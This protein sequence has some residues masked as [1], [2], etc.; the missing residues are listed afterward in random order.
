[1]DYNPGTLS[2]TTW[3]RR[4]VNSGS[5]A[6]SILNE[7]KITVE[8][9]TAPTITAPG[10]VTVS[11]NASCEATGVALGT[12]VTA[13][14]CSVASVSNNAPETF[15]LGE[16]TVTWTVID[17]AGL[18]A[19]AEQTV[20]VEDNIAPTVVTQNITVQ[21]D[22]NGSATITA[23]QI[24]NGST[25][26]CSIAT[27]ALDITS[28]DCDNVGPN[29]VTLTVTDVNG[30][31][32]SETATVTVEDNVAPII[33]TSAKDLTVESDGM[34]NAVEFQNWLDNNGGAEALDNCNEITWTYEFAPISDDCGATGSTKV[35]FKAI[36]ASGNTSTTT[37]TFTIEDTTAP[38]LSEI[39]PIVPT[40]V[41]TNFTLTVPYVDVNGV[42]IATWYFNSDGVAMGTPDEVKIPNDQNITGNSISATFNF[43]ESQAGVYSVLLVVKDACGN[44]AEIGYDYVVVYDPSGGFITGGGWIYS[45]PG[46]MPANPNA[47]GKANF[48][49]NA[50]YKTGKNNMT[51]VDGNTNFQFKEGDFHFKSSSH[52]D[53]SLVI[54]GEKK[55]TYRGVGS[56]NGSGSHYF[57][58]TVIDGD[59]PGGNGTDYF[60]IVVYENGSTSPSG[61]PI[62]DNELE[63]SLNADASTEIGGGSIVIHKPKGNGKTKTMESSGEK[64]G[65]EAVEIAILEILNSLEV[66]P[67]PMSSSTEI[68]FS[69]KERLKAEL[70]IYDYNGKLVRSL[71]S[72]VVNANEVVQV[73]FNRE[74][75]MSGVYI[76]KLFTGNGR[77]YE[78][79]ILIK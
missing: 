52:E 78:K 38:D 35:T 69:L 64:T 26:N 74:N 17:G 32:A 22:A 57:V 28:F 71:Y 20:T 34:G 75:L 21:L 9:V 77:T 37:A 19:T 18:T 65:Y 43:D 61:Q 56:V 59:A 55:A 54:S 16:T 68:R 6:E 72:Q 79:Q 63:G 12:P 39:S 8:D 1:M 42:S 24:N 51:E 33:T 41:N 25:D 5:C 30:N 50:K 76:C 70:V 44:E 73:I 53:M 31:E 15:P 48:G 36:D 13:D 29:T 4:K 45:L 14:N 47:A 11:A 66:A 49:F 67:N 3:Y 60:R 7:V 10:T 46:S 2:Q 27:Y 23:A 58:V 40:G 62:Y